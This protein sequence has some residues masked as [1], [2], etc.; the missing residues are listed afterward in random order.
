MSGEPVRGAFEYKSAMIHIGEHV[1]GPFNDVEFLLG[2][3]GLE[4]LFDCNIFSANL[5]RFWYSGCEW[6]HK[7][8]AVVI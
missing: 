2:A 7:L 1:L 6:W 5:Q 3:D 8:A 4:E